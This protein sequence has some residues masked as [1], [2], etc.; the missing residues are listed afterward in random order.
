MKKHNFAFIDIE[1]TGLN[2]LKH[3]IIE[4]GCVLTTP[5]LEIIEEFELKIKPENISS[6]DPVA[7]KVNHYNEEEWNSA[8]GL[9]NALKILC[10]KA[11]DCIMVG[12][13]VSFDAG[14]LEY[15][16]NKNKILNT[17][18]YHKL[19]TVSVAWAKLHNDP[20]FERLS[21]HELCIRFDIKNKRAHSAL[22]DAHATFE[23][24]KKLME[25]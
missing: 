17:M 23:L 5:E 4:V 19:D 21:L 9:K 1:T 8:V 10:E 3:E 13:N 6:A 2:L 24:Y 11:K 20:D 18:H 22:P 25:L 16:F 15:A 7:L 14:F 12:H